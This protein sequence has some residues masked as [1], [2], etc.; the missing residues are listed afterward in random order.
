MYTEENM[1]YS[2]NYEENYDENNYSYDDN[3]NGNSVWSLLLRILII[4]LC[5]LLEIWIISKFIGSKGNKNDGVVFNDN[6]NTFHLASEKY[7]F[8]ENNLPQNINDSITISLKELN[9]K[10][11]I[12]ELK[13]YQNKTCN[14]DTSSSYATLTKTN[15]AYELVI[16]LTCNSEQKEVTY[17]YDLESMECLS[18]NGNTYMD[19]S[20][21]IEDSKKD[22]NNEIENEEI[23]KLNI[24]CNNWSDWTSTKIDDDR[25]S[26]KTR[27]LYKGYKIIENTSEWSAWGE[28]EIKEEDGIEVETKEEI[29]DVWSEDKIT[30]DYIVNSDTIKVISAS[31]TNGD[32]TCSTSWKK[33][34]EEV[35]ATKYQSLNADDLVIAVHDTYY[36]T[37]NDDDKKSYKTIYDITYKKKTT[38]CTGGSSVTTY[39]Y[40][41]LTK[42]PVTLYRYRTIGNDEIVY[43]DWVEKLEEGYIKTEEKIEYSYKDNVCKG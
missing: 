36:D 1:A 16:K 3:N 37:K 4:F 8:V 33:V 27:T 18:C 13:D 26:I 6:L 29:M 34:R 30:T 20:L 41:E 9:N 21:V 42:K 5:V 15:I 7:F 14:G 24:N 39:I 38:S 2:N 10:N 35:S 12:S 32:K 19:G 43:S 11:L 31:T 23:E 28:T 22:E 40:Q 25:L 17:Y